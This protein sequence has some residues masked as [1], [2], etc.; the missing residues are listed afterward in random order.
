MNIGDIH[1]QCSI[2][3]EALRQRILRDASRALQQAPGVEKKDDNET[4]P[5]NGLIYVGENR[6]H[7]AFLKR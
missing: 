2:L 7:N 5:D 6:D 3:V 4:A 1:N